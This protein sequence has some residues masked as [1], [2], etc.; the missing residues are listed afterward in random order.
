VSSTARD[1][2]TPRPSGLLPFAAALGPFLLLV[3]RFDFLVDD[4]FISWRYAQHLAAG[5]G[6]VFNV[7]E[8]QPVE[9][10][11][12]LLWV[13]AMA[14][15]HRLGL[16]P[17]VASRA[18]SVGAGVLLC[19]LFCGAV[20][21]RG[22]DRV[23][24]AAA[25]LFFATLPPLVVWATGGL[26]TMPFALCVFAVYERLLPR[27]D[28]GPRPV[29]AGV[30]AMLAT[31]LRADGFVWI[32]I[33][34]AVVALARRREPELRR[35]LRTT[36]A[37][38][39]LAAGGVF[40]WRWLEYG[41]LAPNTARAKVH[42]GALSLE[43]G[44]CYVASM[45]LA[46]PSMPLAV[47][48]ALR[49]RKRDRLAWES[50]AIALGGCGYLV[51]VGGDWMMMYR[52]LVPAMPWIALLFLCGIEALAPRARVAFSGLC[53]VLSLLPCF[54]LHPVPR[55]VRE[56]TH[57]RWGHPRL[58]SEY[59]IWKMGVV[60]IEEWILLGKALALH[61]QAGESCVLG[62]IGAIPYYSGLIAYDTHGLTNREPFAPHDPKLRASPGH[63]RAVDVH[64][65]DRFHPT[66]RGLK[67][68]DADDPYGG[69]PANWTDPNHPA[70][71]TVKIE[72]VPLDPAQ[73]FPE[74]TVLQLVRNIW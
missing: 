51:L 48:A 22:T 61:T 24:A 29:Q 3:W 72:I 23:T 54:D 74:H 56:L 52:M 58:E 45:L 35:A 11:T 37:M 60:D 70:S 14:L 62:N 13:L 59:A 32:A 55:A 64:T 43:R 15:V 36:A 25:A 34:L 20:A 12:N 17:A 6:L 4:A 5:Q 21:R 68:A 47:L 50:A 40:L 38:F 1:P 53:V 44:S 49:A 39:V 69:L 7:G 27:A 19:W 73:G 57:Y 71:A 31:L 41:Q 26:E 10:F 63:D 65:F 30:W 2:N 33:V 42:L 28:G 16:D 67:L 66:Y 46:I 8:A 18:L 9:G